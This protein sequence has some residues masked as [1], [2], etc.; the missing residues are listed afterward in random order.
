MKA[1]I[2][3]VLEFLLALSGMPVDEKHRSELV[4][5]QSTLEELDAQTVYRLVC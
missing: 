4:F 3:P 1:G 2:F 5:C